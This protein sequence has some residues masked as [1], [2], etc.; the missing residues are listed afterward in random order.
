MA[1]TNNNMLSPVGFSFQ[2]NRCPNMN[3][4]IQSVVLPGVNLGQLSVPN[5]FKEV[6]VP[7]D[8]ITYGELDVTFKINEDMSNYLEI[9]NWITA[10]GFPDNY[11]Q[12]KSIA[13]KLTYTG[14]SVYSDATLTILTSSM[15]PAMR[16]EITD[17]FPTALSPITVDSRDSS[18]EY[19]EATASFRF[20][21]YTFKK[22]I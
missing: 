6:P 22:L 8:H 15:N 20:L 21:N 1:V 11:K 2:I 4:F 14:D 17:L 13:E 18:I 12:Y 9:F 7:G 19:I 3:F 5:Q 10:L 16:I